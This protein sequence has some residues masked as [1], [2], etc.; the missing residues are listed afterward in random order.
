MSDG[1]TTPTSTTSAFKFDMT[2]WSKHDRTVGIASLIVFISLFLPW[3]GVSYVTAYYHVGGSVNGLWHGYMY[4]TLII[5]LVLVVYLVL[6]AGLDKLPFSVPMSHGQILLI[7]TAI[8]FILSLISFI[9]KPGYTSW[10]FGAYVG[11]IASAVAVSPFAIPM[12]Q[13]R[14]AKKK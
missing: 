4:L 10:N 11:L 5:S 6:L 9:T 2:K 14:M 13:S 12:V 1:S 3:F 8:D 7:G